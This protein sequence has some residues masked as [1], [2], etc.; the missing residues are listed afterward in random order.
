[1]ISGS[2]PSPSS[3]HL[4]CR[5]SWTSFLLHLVSL[6][7][8]FAEKILVK[9]SIYCLSCLS[10][11]L[12]EKVVFF[13]SKTGLFLIPE[14]SAA[15][16]VNYWVLS[17][18]RSS[19]SVTDVVFPVLTCLLVTPPVPFWWF[20]VCFPAWTLLFFFFFPELRISLSSSLN[21]HSWYK[22]QKEVSVG[23]SRLR[24]ASW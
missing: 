1:M 10:L 24:R 18:S 21:N 11:A 15:V 2:S 22:C 6:M 7:T 12:K 9:H 19:L 16:P 5:F 14:N 3:S 23:G 17:L 13:L 8:A 20:N 4:T